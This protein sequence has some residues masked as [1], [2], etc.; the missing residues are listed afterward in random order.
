MNLSFAKPKN[1]VVSETPSSIDQNFIETEIVLETKTGKIFGTLTTPKTFSTIPVALIIAGSGPTDRN[2]NNSMMKSDAYKKLAHQLAQKNIASVR[3]DKRGIAAS[4]E[5]GLSEADLRFEN[6]IDDAKEWTALLKKDKRFSSTTIIGHSEGS[7]IGMI[8]AKNANKYISIAGPGQSADKVLK[9]QFKSQPKEIQEI[10][11]PIIDSL[12][13]GKLVDKVDPNFNSL[14]RK[15]V[16]PYLISWYK[17]DPQLEIQKLKIP[18]LILQG[19]NDIQVSVDEAKKLSAA[20]KNAK[21]VIIENMNHVC[22]IIEGDRQANMA[23][24]NKSN[25]PLAPELISE[26]TDFILQK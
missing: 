21:L 19:T 23:T 2:C 15:S 11:F 4:I 7:T 10:A 5:A 25:L 26:I 3:Y 22:I 20:N 17:C 9:T 6:Y 24:Y 13:S 1:E 16:Q 12:S 14:F 18:V 8:A